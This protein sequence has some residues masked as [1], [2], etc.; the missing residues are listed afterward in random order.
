[1]VWC[2]YQS[3]VALAFSEF[4]T[5][6]CCASNLPTHQY[7][8]SSL[9]LP[10]PKLDSKVGLQAGCTSIILRHNANKPA[11]L[12]CTRTSLRSR[13]PPWPAGGRPGARLPP[14]RWPR[15]RHAPR[16]T[17]QR[18]EHCSNKDILVE[19]TPTT[20]NISATSLQAP[21]PCRPGH[22]GWRS[23]A[24][25]PKAAAAGAQGGMHA[26][27]HLR[28]LAAGQPENHGAVM[29]TCGAR[30]TTGGN[31]GHQLISTHSAARNLHS[32]LWACSMLSPCAATGR[33][34]WL[35]ACHPHD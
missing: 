20:S 5:L 18:L 4:L 8:L 6:L 33:S 21:P 16:P 15:A 12:A 3:A 14:T 29:T 25:K 1:M 28:R 2:A 26:A 27:A 11:W 34:R 30:L 7:T 22:A 17:I 24:G 9:G 13:L 35:T 32:Q 19:R 31:S 10:A 23:M